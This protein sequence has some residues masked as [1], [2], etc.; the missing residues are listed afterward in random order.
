MLKYEKGSSLS[1]KAKI[2]G[3]A[4]YLQENNLGQAIFY[5]AKL[6]YSIKYAQDIIEG[7]P[8]NSQL[9]HKYRTFIEHLKRRYGVKY[10]FQ[11]ESE[12]DWPHY[13][14]MT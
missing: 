4:A 3:I 13:L 1:T 6:S 14:I 5:C 9:I 8:T 12:H 10:R 7:L 2:I 11:G